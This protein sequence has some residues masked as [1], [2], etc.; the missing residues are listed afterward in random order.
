MDEVEKVIM[1]R[2]KIGKKFSNG[3][4]LSLEKAY[5]KPVLEKV[6]IIS[7][8]CVKIIYNNLNSSSNKEKYS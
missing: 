2:L 5:S 6:K 3:V 8:E 4:Q 1:W 7:L